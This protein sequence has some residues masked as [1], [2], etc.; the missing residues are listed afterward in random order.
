MSQ[1]NK[2]S[3]SLKKVSLFFY[4]LWFF[5]NKVWLCFEIINGLYKQL[6]LMYHNN[7]TWE[8][9]NNVSPNLKE[10]DR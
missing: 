7:Y 2:Y 3:V 9:A 10:E 6:Y 4:T 8:N 5:I 1:K